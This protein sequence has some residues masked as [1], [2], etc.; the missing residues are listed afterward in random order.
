MDRLRALDRACI[1]TLFP[2]NLECLC[3]RKPS[4]GHPLCEECAEILEDCRITGPVCPVCGHPLRADAACAFCKGDGLTARSAYRHAETA[5]LLVHTL[6]FDGV[7]AAADV[8]TEGMAAAV[9]A[10]GPF[11]AVTWVTMPEKRK[12]VRGIDH[13]RLLAEGVARRLGVPCLCLLSRNE[14]NWKATQL[15]MNA[16]ER[17]KHLEQAFLCPQPV[18]GRILLADD[19]MTTG[20]T[21]RAC[22]AA[23][24]QAGAASVTVVTATQAAEHETSINP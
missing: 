24:L 21:A 8:F 2:E 16:E 19:V 15:G 5:R 23:L 4:F 6:K 22:A 17:R 11:D 14:R 3:C 10:L 1:D 12:R 7:S 20:S 13:G 9:E 18:R